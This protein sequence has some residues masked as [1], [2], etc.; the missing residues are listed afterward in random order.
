MS[1]IFCY[2]TDM[3]IYTRNFPVC[4]SGQLTYITGLFNFFFVLQDLINRIDSCFQS[5]SEELVSYW[6][7]TLYVT[8]FSRY[9]QAALTGMA[10]RKFKRRNYGGKQRVIMKYQNTYS[11]KEGLILLCQSI[12]ETRRITYLHG[13]VHCKIPLTTVIWERNQVHLGENSLV[14]MISEFYSYP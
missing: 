13:S 12:L 11:F 5:F 3:N 9:K 4:N 14:I 2:S 8:S 1:S 7:L 6:L 10:L